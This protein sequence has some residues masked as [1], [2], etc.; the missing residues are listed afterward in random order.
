MTL[1]FKIPESMLGKEL[2]LPYA[3]ITEV[4]LKE[5][6]TLAVHRILGYGDQQSLRRVT[7]MRER[8]GS[9]AAH[10][11]DA[12]D[13]TFTA[14]VR[15]QTR[16]AAAASFLQG[17]VVH[18]VLRRIK[19]FGGSEAAVLR[20]LLEDAGRKLLNHMNGFRHDPRPWAGVGIIPCAPD[21]SQFIFARK[22]H[23]HPCPWYAGRLSLIGGAMDLHEMLGDWGGEAGAAWV[24]MLRECYEEIRDVRTAGEVAAAVTSYHG[25]RPARCH[26]SDENG[27]ANDGFLR[28]FTARAPDAATWEHWL[29]TLAGS[30]ERLS[31]AEP[32]VVSHETLAA[33]LRYDRGVAAE[34]DAY[35]LAAGT[36]R[37]Q[38]ESNS[39]L[40]RFSRK[41]VP[42]AREWKVNR[43]LA[44]ETGEFPLRDRGDFVFIAGAAGAIE[45]VLHEDGV[46]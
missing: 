4:H 15:E 9:Y 28:L 38:A 18:D 20:G 34:R 1:F 25:E 39:A 45:Y 29:D 11:S 21:G 32:E 5:P 8:D 36:A 7:F 13:S 31:E 35:I 19:N 26:L 42:N 23:L 43:D 14:V 46:L 27:A 16:V 44:Q 30:P 10:L 12:G 41:F 2:S 37:M 24:A 33:A 22:D 17:D 6:S 3:P 40:W